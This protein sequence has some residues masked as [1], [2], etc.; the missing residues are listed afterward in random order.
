MF[1]QFFLSPQVKRWVIITYKHGIYE[2]PHENTP[3]HFRRWGG[4]CAHTRKKKKK[5][6][7]GY[8]PHGE[9]NP[10]TK[11]LATNRPPSTRHRPR[12]SRPQQ[13]FPQSTESNPH[14]TPHRR[15]RHQPTPQTHH[16]SPIHHGTENQRR[17]IIR[18]TRPFK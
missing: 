9:V 14:A 8:L 5:K 18:K 17:R 6:I 16:T 1:Y 12:G 10:I 7:L 15:T 13:E 4:L 11:A 3:R 2:L